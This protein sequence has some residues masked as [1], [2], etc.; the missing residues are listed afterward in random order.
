MIFFKTCAGPR[1]CPLF[2]K[3]RMVLHA[4]TAFHFQYGREA[5]KLSLIKAHILPVTPSA[6]HKL[7]FGLLSDLVAFL[8]DA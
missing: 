3:V 5:P 8:K 4:V 2:K 6:V 7:E 1:H